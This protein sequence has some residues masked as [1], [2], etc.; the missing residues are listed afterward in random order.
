MPQ[1]ASQDI[2]PITCLF[3]R[4]RTT[5]SDEH[6]FCEALGYFVVMRDVCESCNNTLGAVVDAAADA[7]PI[8][9]WARKRAG[10]HIRGQAI[11]HVDDAVD[12]EGRTVRSTWSSRSA[13]AVAATTWEDGALIASAEVMPK[14]LRKTIKGYA[15]RERLP[16]DPT[17]VEATV[18][19]LLTAYEHAPVGAVVRAEYLGHGV[20]ITK[21]EVDT[22]TIVHF[23][24]EEGMDRLFA[25]I[26]IEFVAYALG[27]ATHLLDPGFDEVRRFVRYGENPR[28]TNRDP[29]DADSGWCIELRAQP[30]PHRLP[31]R[32]NAVR[33][34]GL[35]PGVRA[36]GA[37]GARYRPL[38]GRLICLFA[39][40]HRP[41]SSQAYHPL[42]GWAT[43]AAARSR[44][45]AR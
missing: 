34:S 25:K 43:S 20:T 13:S 8:L 3:C 38:A 21:G 39:D 36:R 11:R 15:R 28:T 35:I 41:Q 37:A 26:A 19:E 31:S 6:I 27:D 33:A 12:T 22:T 1:G 23:R 2:G 32:R 42:K 16:Y 9:A 40:V 5:P 44:A 7:D 4:S 45:C 10:L 30:H 18:R 14:E 24:D 29:H 17:A